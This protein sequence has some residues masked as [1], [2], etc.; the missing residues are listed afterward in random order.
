MRSNFGPKPQVQIPSAQDARHQWLTVNHDHLVQIADTAI[1][2]YNARPHSAH[3]LYSPD[4]VQAGDTHFDF[5]AA[6]ARAFKARLECNRNS[7]CTRCTCK[8]P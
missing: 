1:A 6:K 8:A 5:P 4:E 2:E 7:P 3:L